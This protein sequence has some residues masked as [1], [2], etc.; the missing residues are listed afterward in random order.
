G[1]QTCALPILNT[2]GFNEPNVVCIPKTNVAESA[3]VIKNVAINNNVKIDMIKP[4]G[5]SLN[6]P[7]SAVS[8][9]ISNIFGLSLAVS[10]P[11]TPNA[12]NHTKLT[13]T[14]ANITPETN[15]LIER[16]LDTR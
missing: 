14:G 15:S 5:T 9:G 8:G 16:P 2:E 4:S 7:N 3:D 1:V 10:I 13:S 6:T 11:K 12:A